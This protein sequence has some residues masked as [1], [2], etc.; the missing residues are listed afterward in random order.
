M[1]IRVL[2]SVNAPDALDDTPLMCV[3]DVSYRK[4]NAHATS[5]LPAVTPVRLIVRVPVPVPVLSMLEV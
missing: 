5:V 2:A 1:T 3:A 4:V